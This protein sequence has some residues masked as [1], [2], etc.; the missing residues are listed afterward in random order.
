MR[1]ERL[2]DPGATADIDAI[3]ALE[4]ESGSCAIPT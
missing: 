3:T 4:S 2:L 1:V